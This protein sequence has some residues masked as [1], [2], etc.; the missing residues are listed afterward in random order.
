MSKTD[1]V[2]GIHPSIFI[3]TWLFHSDLAHGHRFYIRYYKNNTIFKFTNLNIVQIY[4]WLKFKFKSANFELEKSVKVVLTKY[5]I[6]A[7]SLAS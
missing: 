7:M 5:A 2:F 4:S 6:N 1:L 3:T